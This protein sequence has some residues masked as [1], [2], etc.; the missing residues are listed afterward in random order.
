MWRRY[1]ANG[2]VLVGRVTCEEHHAIGIRDEN[3]FAAAFPCRLQGI[4]LNPYDR[5]AK[6][7]RAADRLG[8]IIADA[9]AGRI[10]AEIAAAA[11]LDRFHEIGAVRQSTAD[12][13]LRRIRMSGS[14]H[15]A[16]ASNDIE[17]ARVGFADDALEFLAELLLVGFGV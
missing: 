7:R 11:R 15:R 9:I 5:D 6:Q 3:A 13:N 12:K 1:P 10:N 16:V 14:D 2:L 17:S 4:E 8:Q